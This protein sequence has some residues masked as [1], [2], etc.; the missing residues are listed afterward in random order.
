MNEPNETPAP[1][2]NRSRWVVV[3]AVLALAG[4]IAV[5]ATQWSKP[6]PVQMPPPPEPQ[7]AGAL[8]EGHPPVD[9]STGM[10]P[11]ALPPGS[12]LPAGHPSFDGAGGAGA[13]PPMSNP[14]GDPGY[15]SIEGM[16]AL[17]KAG[18]APT[19]RRVWVDVVEGI[20]VSKLSARQKEIYLRH[21]NSEDCICGYSVASCRAFNPPCTAGPGKAAALLDSVRTGKYKDAQGLRERPAGGF[22]T[23]HPTA[24]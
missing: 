22:P 21:A 19:N 17:I 2:Q 14:G 5:A 16:H 1:P 23:G 10:P 6:Q 9:A 11:A 18:L 15:V 24:N 13:M 20:D 7:T 8:P 3:I 12:K 4:G